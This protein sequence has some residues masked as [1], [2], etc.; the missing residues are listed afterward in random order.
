MNTASVSNALPYKHF[1]CQKSNFWLTLMNTICA[2]LSKSSQVAVWNMALA[3][4]QIPGFD[5]SINR[6]LYLFTGHVM[7]YMDM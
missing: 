2:M 6:L 4:D 3:A 1:D 7:R 5:H